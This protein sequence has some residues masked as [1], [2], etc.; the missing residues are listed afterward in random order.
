MPVLQTL[1]VRINRKDESN[2]FSHEL[3]KHLLIRPLVQFYE[4]IRQSTWTIGTTIGVFF[5]DLN[6]TISALPPIYYI[7]TMIKHKL[8]WDDHR[9][10]IT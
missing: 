10:I 6:N 1:L 5:V 4:C 8:T 2:S 3:R 9:M 7:K